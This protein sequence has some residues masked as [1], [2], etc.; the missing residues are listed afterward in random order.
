MGKWLKFEGPLPNRAIRENWVGRG[1]IKMIEGVWF[2]K[3]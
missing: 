2:Y 3:R 1:W